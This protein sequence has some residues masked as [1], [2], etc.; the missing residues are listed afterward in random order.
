LLAD[1]DVEDAEIEWFDLP[2]ERR[3]SASALHECTRRCM[4]DATACRRSIG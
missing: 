4:P 1:G 2:A 3:Q